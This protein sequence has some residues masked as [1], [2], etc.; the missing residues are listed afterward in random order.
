[1]KHGDFTSLAEAYSLSR[2]GY[3]PQV[4]QSIKK[5]ANLDSRSKVIDVG[6]GTGIWTKMLSKEIQCEILAVEPNREMYRAGLGYTRDMDIKWINDSAETFKTERMSA[7]LI[8]MASSFH[9]TKY[10]QSINN[11]KNILKPE[12][13]FCALWN[14]RAYELNPKLSLI[15]NHLKT[16]LSQPRISSGRSEFT[17]NLHLR[18]SSSFGMENVIYLDGYHEESMTIERYLKIW[19]S[20]N[21][22]QVQLGDR[23]FEEFK[24]FIKNIFQG[25]SKII[26]TYQTRAWLARK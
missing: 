22:V 7:D 9:W 14:T 25:D 23:K 8:T 12:A 21:D 3:A 26:A 13:F 4:L 24:N 10:D 1:M 15:E 19:E 5:I 2:P 16:L 17:Q 20:V 11:F 6:A 18:L